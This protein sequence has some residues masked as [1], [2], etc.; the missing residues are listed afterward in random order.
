MP[1]RRRL[2][3]DR[4]KSPVHEAPKAQPMG[5]QSDRPTQRLQGPVVLNDATT[6]HGRRRPERGASAAGAAGS[7]GDVPGLA[8]RQAA[9]KLLAAVIDA[10]TPLDGL[11]D[12]DHGHPNFRALD[13]RDRALV[14]AILATALQISRHDRAR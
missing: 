9:A 12:H 10:R 11:T 3:L 13:M 8:A 1:G 6:R 14:R 5:P 2:P 4:C 7:A